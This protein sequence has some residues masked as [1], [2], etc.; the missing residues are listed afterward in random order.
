MPALLG[1]SL[2]VDQPAAEVAVD[3]GFLQQEVLSFMTDPWDW[4]ISLHLA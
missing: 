3:V 1:D 4:Y 2:K